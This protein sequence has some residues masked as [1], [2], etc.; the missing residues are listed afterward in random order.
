M[1]ADQVA[2]ARRRPAAPLTSMAFEQSRPPRRAA[3]LRDTMIGSSVISSPTRSRVIA[4]SSR[5]PPLDPGRYELVLG[6]RHQAGQTPRS[7]RSRRRMPRERP[8]GSRRRPRRRAC[9]RS[10]RAGLRTAAISARSVEP[11]ARRER[12]DAQEHADERDALHAHEQVRPRRVRSRQRRGV[13]R[14]DA[15]APREDLRTRRCRDGRPDLRPDPSSVRLDE[16]RA[17]VD[18]P[19]QR[20]ALPKAATSWSGTK[21]TRSSSACVWMRLVGDGQEVRGRQALLLR[22][23]ARIRLDVEAEELAD[24]RG[25][26]LVRGDRAEAADRVAAH[27]DRRRSGRGRR[28]ARSSA[29]GWRTPS[30]AYR[31]S[32]LARLGQPVEDRGDVAGG[33]VA[34]AQTGRGRQRRAGCRLAVARRRRTSAALTSR[35]SGLSAGRRIVG[36]FD[37]ARRARARWSASASS[38]GRERA[39]RGDRHRSRPSRPWRAEMVDDGDRRCRRWCPWRRRSRSASSQR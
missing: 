9:R 29:S 18:E 1:H 22:A 5:S 35:V 10:G 28:S 27:A 31:R 2:V 11:G 33:D 7:R 15:D 38:R 39:E 24:E 3:G 13:E 14:E 19:A 30:T 36:P 23:V 20:V 26:E 4:W 17:A 8:P 6:C 32:W 25:E 34:R 21:S 16:H 12:R 37:D